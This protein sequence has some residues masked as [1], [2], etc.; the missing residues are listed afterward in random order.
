MFKIQSSNGIYIFLK[1]AVYGRSSR[2]IRKLKVLL[3]EELFLKTIVAD[4]GGYTEW[5]YK[6]YLFDTNKS[7]FIVFDMIESESVDIVCDLSKPLSK[8]YQN[9]ADIVICS[10]II[11]YIKDPKILIRNAISVVK[12]GGVI[13]ID[14]PQ[15]MPIIEKGDINRFT[16]ASITCLVDEFKELEIMEIIGEG[17]GGNYFYSLLSGYYKSTP[18]LY[19]IILLLLSLPFLLFFRISSIAGFYNKNIG[20]SSALIVVA[21]RV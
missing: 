19:F 20:L 8:K 15:L 14:M 1:N 16:A 5:K 13:I 7:E 21:K 17:E 4:F 18:I 11:Q 3:K 2:V 9:R 12:K 6:K 10:A